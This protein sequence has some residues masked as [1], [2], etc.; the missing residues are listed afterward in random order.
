MQGN[1]AIAMGRSK[2]PVIATESGAPLFGEGYT[3]RYGDV[4]WARQGADAAVVTMGTVAGAA[5]AASDLLRA[6]GLAVGVAICASP[7]DLDAEALGPAAEVPLVLT[8][9]DH[10]VRTGLG[11]SVAEFLESTGSR[12]RLVRVGVEAYQSS[13]ASADLL[14]AAGLDA[15]G[16]ASRVRDE[17]G[18]P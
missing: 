14:K 4:V 3:F 9:E 16:I 7:L 15:E 5:V 8:A 2:L 17:L 1:V 18:R 13:G 6:E 12:A 10:G 11:A